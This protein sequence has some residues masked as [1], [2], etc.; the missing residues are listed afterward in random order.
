M[1]FKHLKS[2][3]KILNQNMSGITGTMLNNLKKEQVNLTQLCN[4][5]S[6]TVVKVSG[7]NE[8]MSKLE[9]MG[10]VPGSIITKKSA[11][12]AKGPIV[13]ERDFVQF[14]IGYDIARKIIV[15]PANNEGCL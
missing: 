4:G 5:T 15:Q 1:V 2:H 13:I 6:A 8:I 10:I 12:L 9:T 7:N 3:K 14:A 11:I